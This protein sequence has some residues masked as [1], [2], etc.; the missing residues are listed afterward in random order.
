MRNLSNSLL[1]QQSISGYVV[2]YFLLKLYEIIID[3]YP[4]TS[5]YL[6][7]FAVICF[8]LFKKVR[9]LWHTEIKHFGLYKFCNW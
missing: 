3:L 6:L 5:K 1:L 7:V 8:L 4:T 2:W 9:D